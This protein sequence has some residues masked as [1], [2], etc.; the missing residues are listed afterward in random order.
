MEFFAHQ[1]PIPACKCHK[2]HHALT[3]QQNWDENDR[4]GDELWAN[5]VIYRLNEKRGKQY[6]STTQ[7]VVSMELFGN[8]RILTLAPAFPLFEQA[9]SV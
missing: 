6:V 9:P 7:A 1:T 2:D 8:G 5:T 3:F 4:K